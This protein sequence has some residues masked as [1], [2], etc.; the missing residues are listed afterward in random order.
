[1]CRPHRSRSEQATG[2]GPGLGPRVLW[3]RRTPGPAQQEA[4]R[5]EGWA[6]QPK[7]TGGGRGG[8]PVGPEGAGNL[9]GGRAGQCGVG[10]GPGGR[11]ARRGEGEPGR[12]S[13][14]QDQEPALSKASAPPPLPRCAP[15]WG[16]P[17][18]RNPTMG[19]WRALGSFLGRP[20]PAPPSGRTASPAARDGEV[21][22]GGTVVDHGASGFGGS[23]GWLEGRGQDASTEAI[24]GGVCRK[25]GGGE[26][27][28]Q[29]GAGPAGRRLPLS[30]PFCKTGRQQQG[31][32]DDPEEGPREPSQGGVP[33]RALG[34]LP[35]SPQRVACHLLPQ[36]AWPVH[37]LRP[38]VS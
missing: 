21:A 23:R 33:A 10:T 37:H 26:A 12:A 8:C 19:S 20:P 11:G 25:T 16:P 30:L 36:R 14:R 32:C 18:N 2:W 31:C 35:T 22:A 1:M 15:A 38:G 7:E 5:R 27:G 24:G 4:Q 28:R 6:A 17:R 34:L 13:P 9:R 29:G 3:T